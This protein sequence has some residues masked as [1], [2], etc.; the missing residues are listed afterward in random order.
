MHSSLLHKR[1]HSRVLVYDPASISLHHKTQTDPDAVPKVPAASVAAHHPLPS[2]NSRRLLS[3]AGPT[4][5][6]PPGFSLLSQEHQAVRALRHLPG[7]G[8]LYLSASLVTLGHLP[9][10][11]PCQL[12]CYTLTHTQFQPTAISHYLTPRTLSTTLCL[13]KC[14]ANITFK[15]HNNPMK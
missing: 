2:L 6:H 10:G 11:L 15:P 12:T 1:F 13:P 14:F 4:H 9:A 7:A 8:C 3:I 5:P